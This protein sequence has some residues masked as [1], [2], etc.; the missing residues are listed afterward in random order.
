VQE[1]LIAALSK[2]EQHPTL[3]AAKSLNKTQSAL[4]GAFW[5]IGQH[6]ATYQE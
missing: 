4:V 1:D 6:Y 2:D 3:A 5:R